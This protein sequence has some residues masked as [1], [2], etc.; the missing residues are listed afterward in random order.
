MAYKIYHTPMV[1]GLW[2]AFGDRT[3]LEK[4]F[5]YTCEIKGAGSICSVFS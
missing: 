1:L 3:A 5:Q 4:M 2:A